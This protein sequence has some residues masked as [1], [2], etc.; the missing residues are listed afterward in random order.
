M[1]PEPDSSE[2][3]FVKVRFHLEPDEDGWPPASSE[4]LWAEPLGGD[5]YRVDNTPWFVHDLAADDIVVAVADSDG[6][7]WVTHRAVPSGRLTIRI[8]PLDGD[9]QFVLDQFAPFGVTG[10]GI[11]QLGMVALEIAPDA[12]LAA[13][14]ARLQQGEADGTWE[15]EEGCVDDAWSEA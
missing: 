13:I 9:R 1:P 8:I 4:G 7:L 15:Y 6:V 2:H 10:E 11:E 12:D 5:R 14:K 3:D